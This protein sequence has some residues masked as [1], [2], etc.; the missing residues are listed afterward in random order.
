MEDSLMS[1]ASALHRGRRIAEKALR[2]LKL[3]LIELQ[4]VFLK[5]N[6]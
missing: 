6:K 3:S 5:I 1:A 2:E 4:G